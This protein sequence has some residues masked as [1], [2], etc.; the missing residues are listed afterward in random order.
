M[1]N[2]LLISPQIMMRLRRWIPLWL[3]DNL[4]HSRDL[5]IV[6]IGQEAD[7]IV[8]IRR[9]HLSHGPELRRKIGMG[10]KK[11]HGRKSLFIRNSQNEK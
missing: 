1:Q 2:R 8:R 10:Q 7:L 6:G 9:Q 4:L 3:V 11:S 5:P